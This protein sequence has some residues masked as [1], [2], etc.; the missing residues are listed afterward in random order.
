MP[1]KGPDR[2]ALIAR[3]AEATEESQARIKALGLPPSEY[4]ELDV[5][6]VRHALGRKVWMPPEAVPS[7]GLNGQHGHMWL[8]D[9]YDKGGRILLSIDAWEDGYDWIHA[10]MSRSGTVPIY[11]EVKHLHR[12]VFRDGWAYQVFAPPDEHVNDHE[13]C[14]HLWGRLDGTPALPNF[15]AMGSV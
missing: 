13:F 12:A 4:G 15:A 7:V 2:K 6:R 9:R 14:L 5:L 3:M 8:L 1:Q 10:S 11:D